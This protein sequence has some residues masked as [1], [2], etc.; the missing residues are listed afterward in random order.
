MYFLLVTCS[1]LIASRFHPEPILMEL[2]KYLA[3]SR[4]FVVYC[5]FQEVKERTLNSVILSPYTH[6]I[7]VCV[8]MGFGQSFLHLN[9]YKFAMKQTISKFKGEYVRAM[10]VLICCLTMLILLLLAFG[11]VLQASEGVWKDIQYSAY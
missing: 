6:F 5:Q 11:S 2:L 9:V 3:P 7:L 1:L 8:C 4:V 10:F